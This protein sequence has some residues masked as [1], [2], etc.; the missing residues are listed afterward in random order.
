MHMT[1]EKIEEPKPEVEHPAKRAARMIKELHEENI[2]K[3]DDGFVFFKGDVD[4]S[5]EMR[6][7]CVEQIKMCEQIM[8]RAEHMDP[9]LWEPSLQIATDAQ[10]MIDEAKRTGDTLATIM[11]DIGNYDHKE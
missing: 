2:K 8:A 6:A 4:V 3:I 11:P 5:E 9:S 1:F 10:H 7:A